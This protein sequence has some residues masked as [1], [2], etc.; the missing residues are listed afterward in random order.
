[1]SDYEIV[2]TIISLVTLVIAAVALGLSIRPRKKPSPEARNGHPLHAENVRN[3]G[4]LS[5][6]NG[7]RPSHIVAQGKRPRKALINLSAAL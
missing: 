1:M 5:R 3:G 6:A 4:G 2:S 7:C